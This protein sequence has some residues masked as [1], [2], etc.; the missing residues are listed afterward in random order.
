MSGGLLT[1]IVVDANFC[2]RVFV[3]NAQQT[4]LRQQVNLWRNTN[5]LLHAPT[6]WHYELVSTLTKAVHF[7]QFKKDEAQIILDH[8]NTFEIELHPPDADLGKMAFAWTLQLQRA[9]AYDSFYL[10]LAQKLQCEL[11]TVDRRL[12]RAAKVT[13]V[14]YV[15]PEQE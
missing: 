12:Y 11:W 10:A 9:G 6:L 13:W 14:R 5:V 8:L 4:A 2:Y 3:P 7:G 1:N 15:G